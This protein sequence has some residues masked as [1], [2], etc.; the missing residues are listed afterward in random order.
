M[1]LQ[2]KAY[3]AEEEDDEEGI[4]KFAVASRPKVYG[5]IVGK[6]RVGRGWVRP[7]S[8][9]NG[10][11]GGSGVVLGSADQTGLGLLFLVDPGLGFGW[12]QWI[13]GW[14]R[15]GQGLLHHPTVVGV[16]GGLTVTSRSAG[17]SALGAWA[18]CSSGGSRVECVRPA[19]APAAVP[20]SGLAQ[21]L[22]QQFPNPDLQM[23]RRLGRAT[24]GHGEG[25]WHVNFS[26]VGLGGGLA[27]QV[28]GPLV[29]E[30]LPPPRL[31]SGLGLQNSDRG[32][33]GVAQYAVF[34]VVTSRADK[35]F[36][37]AKTRNAPSLLR[38]RIYPFTAAHF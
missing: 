24:L 23:H 18:C 35:T 14:A 25:E 31:D 6:V 16:K 21:G 22:W 38:Y 28:Y 7:S 29:D 34:G 11:Q 15:V 20:G 2:E 12:L 1:L 26:R 3:E 4:R 17:P 37:A 8:P 33:G 30:T 32:E 19:V 13:Q 27:S 5:P 10:C 9:P 36:S